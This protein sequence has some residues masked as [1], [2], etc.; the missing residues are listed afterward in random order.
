MYGGPGAK[1]GGEKEE[2]NE[3]EKKGRRG[4]TGREREEGKGR[5]REKKR[6]RNETQKLKRPKCSVI[7]EQILEIISHKG[8]GI[9]VCRRR[10]ELSFPWILSERLWTER[11]QASEF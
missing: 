1:L 5:K 8:K 11:M 7:Q 2:K 9:G 4:G 6:G 10:T 3:E